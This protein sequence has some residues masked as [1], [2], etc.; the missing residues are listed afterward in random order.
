MEKETITLSDQ[1]INERIENHEH[2]LSLIKK[3]DVIEV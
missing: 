1:E 2:F 3:L